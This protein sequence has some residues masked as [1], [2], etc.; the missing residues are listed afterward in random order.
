[1]ADAEAIAAQAG[2]VPESALQAREN[3][4]L[5][6]IDQSMLLE[7]CKGVTEEHL[8][9]I[10]ELL[11]SAV[12]A[13]EFNVLP[14][15]IARGI[16]QERLLEYAADPASGER[17]KSRALRALNDGLRRC[18]SGSISI[19]GQFHERG[20]FVPRDASRAFGHELVSA[21]IR[22]IDPA[23]S[24]VINTRLQALDSEQI[25]IGAYIARQIY[26]NYC[27]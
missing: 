5:A 4:A 7:L 8:S 25:R 12:D 3:A 10:D 21:W 27:Q 16:T 13:D 1:R 2:G 26:K 6:L 22:N 17:F 24:P 18:D 11:R 9:F 14:V 19:L 15:F 20:L 23:N